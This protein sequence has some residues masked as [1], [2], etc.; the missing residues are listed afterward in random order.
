LPI[1][2]VEIS[3][4]TQIIAGMDSS[5]HPNPLLE[6]EPRKTPPKGIFFAATNVH[7]D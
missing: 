1:G 2:E 7:N 4:G 5:G 6:K 3:G